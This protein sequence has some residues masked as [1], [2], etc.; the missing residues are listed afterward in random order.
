MGGDGLGSVSSGPMPRPVASLKVNRWLGEELRQWRRPSRACSAIPR[1]RVT[2]GAACGGGGAAAAFHRSPNVLYFV[3][4]VR[5]RRLATALDYALG[6]FD[7]SVV[8]A[9][10]L[11]WPVDVQAA[12]AGLVVLLAD[13][14][15]EAMY[16]KSERSTKSAASDVLVPVRAGPTV[17]LAD[18]DVA[19]AQKE[20]GDTGSNSDST[21]VSSA[22]SG[23]EESPAFARSA[24]A[25][26]AATTTSASVQAEFT[27]GS[28]PPTGV[29]GKRARRAGT[30]VHAPRVGTTGGADTNTPRVKRRVVG[31]GRSL[32]IRRHH[33]ASA[34]VGL[35]CARTRRR[36]PKR[37][38]PDGLSGGPAR[39]ATSHPQSKLHG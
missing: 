29:G 15:G 17:S 32:L 28:Q 37:Q 31:V 10:E 25:A 33:A 16:A 38:H 24:P 12:D 35:G 30:T 2:G 34:A 1:T 21:T 20:M 36:A 19:E 7:P 11:P 14:W 22:S 3:W 39:K 5:W 4:W 23:S 9:P 13:L 8:G 26:P 27:V 6:Y 18:M